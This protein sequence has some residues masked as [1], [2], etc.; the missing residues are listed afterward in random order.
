MNYRPLVTITT[1][2]AVALGAAGC[3]SRAA[4]DDRSPVAD[5]GALPGVTVTGSFGEEPTIEVD[6]IDVDE[7]V[8]GVVIPGDGEEV[9]DDSVLNYRF[10][11]VYADDGTEVSG[12]YAED[13]PQQLDLSQ[14]AG[15]IADA[16]VGTTVGSRVAI[17]MKVRDLLGS[18]Q[19]SQYGMKG[20]DELVMVMDLVS[21]TGEPLAG[22]EGESVEPPADAPTIVEEDDAVTGIEFDNAPAKP[23]KK[24][25]V[26]TLVQG[27]GDAV[28]VGDSVTVDYFGSVYGDGQAFDESFSSEP[29]TFSLTEGSLIDGWVKGLEGIKAGSR[30]MLVIPPDLAYGDQATGDIPAG[31]T[32]VFVVDVLGVNL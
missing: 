15:V 29:V 10:R 13:A 6:E 21:M 30:V 5:P 16:L 26:I 2:F 1:T 14:Q 9:V 4:G 7:P 25:D 8:D 11:I 23:G 28:S 3:A 32:L 19:A 22:P 18:G 20:K 31:S 17:A 24:L 12:N 27:T